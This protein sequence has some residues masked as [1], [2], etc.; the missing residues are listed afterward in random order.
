MLISAMAAGG[1]MLRTPVCPG[2]SFLSRAHPSLQLALSP[3]AS[4]QARDCQQGAQAEMCSQEHG[5]KRSA[6]PS[7]AYSCDCLPRP[8]SPC[9]RSP[10]SLSTNLT[11]SPALWSGREESFL[12]IFP[13]AAVPCRWEGSEQRS[14]LTATPQQ[15]GGGLHILVHQRSP[16]PG[17]G[18]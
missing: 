18:T 1:R 15:R 9:H 16:R 8:G 11:L 17:L 6:E 5:W 10:A 4:P 13:L 3:Q 12:D 14:P 7:R 2:T